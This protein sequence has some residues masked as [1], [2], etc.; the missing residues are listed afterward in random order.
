MGTIVSTYVYKYITCVY[1]N[2]VVKYVALGN[3]PVFIAI[4]SI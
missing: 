3:I 1:I 4:H 2:K